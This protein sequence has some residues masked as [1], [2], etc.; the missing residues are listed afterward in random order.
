MNRR[1]LI[2][3]GIIVLGMAVMLYLASRPVAPSGRELSEPV[4]E[5][6]QWNAFTARFLRAG[7]I[8][9]QDNNGITH[10]EGQG[11]GLLLAE[12]AADRA[13]FEVIWTWTRDH[14]LRAD[15]LFAWRYGPCEESHDC[16]IT[17]FNNATDGDILIAWALLR[18]AERWRIPEYHEAARRIVDA[19][20]KH[21]LIKRDGRYLV[22]PGLSGFAETQS[23]TV[24]L[25]YWVF[26][27]FKAFAAQLDAPIW[28]DVA[29]SGRDLILNARFGK[30]NLPPDWLELHGR[31]L[32]P[33]PK[34]EPLYGFNA[35]RIP[36][37]LVWAGET[38]DSLLKP[39]LD[40]WTAG[41][42][43][44]A[45]VNLV[46]NSPAEYGPS[47]GSNAIISITTSRN[48]GKKIAA[49]SLPTPGKDDG[50]YSWSLA[51]LS[52]V[53]LHELEQ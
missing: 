28:R 8:I 19:L 33:S 41:G 40:F 3:S 27:A 11:Y 5:T 30:W 24:N 18:A 26:P 38:S 52:R 51:L 21:A 37:H 13:T 22:L 31:D 16:R 50:Y 23:V 36:L 17:D 43:P 29:D 46:D 2:F 25:S 48:S 9:D 20:E 42:S 49:E 15:S 35:I 47:A 34:F 39:F 44:P 12:A 7:R 32:K 53:A 1:V 10:S 45:W 6:E 14:L 4:L